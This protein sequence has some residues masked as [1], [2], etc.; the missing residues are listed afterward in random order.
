ML[1]WQGVP[2]LVHVSLIVQQAAGAVTVIG[3]PSKYSHLGFT[4]LED[5]EPGL[6]PLE[7][8]RTAL[9]LSTAEW[10]LI[11]ACD[12]PF[13]NPELLARL[14]DEAEQSGADCLMPSGQ[15]LCAVYNRR[16]L[17]Q[18]DQALQTGVRKV[19]QA[20]AGL[21]VQLFDTEEVLSFQNMNR[22]E[23]WLRAL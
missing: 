15:P 14:L 5:G 13:L 17:P 21:R 9:S 20:L 18:I 19:R 8:I 2:L 1:N 23:D 6:G 10:N 4:V 7:G 22:P 3:A 16:C 12:M 11:V